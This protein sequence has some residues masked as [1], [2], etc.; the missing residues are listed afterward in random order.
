M[1]LFYLLG[2]SNAISGTSFN[3]ETKVPLLTA[4]RGSMDRFPEH[5]AISYYYS[6]FDG[7]DF[8]DADL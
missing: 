8:I 2:I 5:T 1:K 6:F 7:A 4:H 3:Y